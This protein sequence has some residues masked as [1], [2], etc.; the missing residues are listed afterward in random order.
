MREL[1]EALSSGTRIV[2]RSAAG[3]PERNEGVNEGVKSLLDC[4]TQKPGQRVPA[5]AKALGVT[6]KTLER[7]LSRLK[8][9]NKIVYKGSPKTGGY[10]VK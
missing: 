9:E 4:I 2:I 3:Y 1:I 10:N 8:A 5:L 6:P 7:W